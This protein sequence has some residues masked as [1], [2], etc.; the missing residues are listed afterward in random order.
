MI[1][2]DGL[3]VPAAPSACPFCGSSK[4]KTAREMVDVSAYW[5]CETCGE[6]WNAGRLKALNRYHR[7]G[8][9]NG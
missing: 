4:V 8:A 3:K 9:S 1:A 2:P 7:S 6:V 5:R